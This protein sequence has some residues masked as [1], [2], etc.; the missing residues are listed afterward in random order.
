MSKRFWDRLSP[1]EQ[2]LI[3]EAA[4]E[5][6]AFERKTIRAFDARPW[7]SSRPRACR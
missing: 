2:K 4:S 5:A 7:R 1:D 6:T 3:T